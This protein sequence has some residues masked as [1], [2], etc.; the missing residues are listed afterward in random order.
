MEGILGMEYIDVTSLDEPD[1]LWRYVDPAGHE[2]AYDTQGKIPT[3]CCVV[4]DEGSDEYPSRG[5]Y[6]CLRCGAR[7]SP[8]RRASQFRSYMRFR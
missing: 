4:D 5:H 3:V 8:G 1:P 6:E 2:H 7:V